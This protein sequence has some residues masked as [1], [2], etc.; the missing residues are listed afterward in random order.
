MCG[1]G[2]KI[3]RAGLVQASVRTFPALFSNQCRVGQPLGLVYLPDKLGHE[4]LT[5][6]LPD[7]PSFSS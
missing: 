7:G 6:L 5:D 2:N 4:E 3:F 1:R